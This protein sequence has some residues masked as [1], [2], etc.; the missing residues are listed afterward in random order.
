MIPDLKMFLN[1]DSNLFPGIDNNEE[2]KIKKES[3]GKLNGNLGV[4]NIN[5]LGS[6]LQNIDKNEY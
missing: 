5:Q 1:S 3:N 2:N 6:L 4:D